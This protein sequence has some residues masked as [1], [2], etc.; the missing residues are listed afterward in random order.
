[1]DCICVMT[2][3][4]VVSFFFASSIW[5]FYNGLKLF[6]RSVQGDLNEVISLKCLN[7]ALSFLIVRPDLQSLNLPDCP[8]IMSSSERFILGLHI[9]GNSIFRPSS[10]GTQALGSLHVG[11]DVREYLQTGPFVWSF[12]KTYDNMP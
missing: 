6:I 8:T 9:V 11:P 12:P 7:I 1:M 10:V 3:W 2:S 5:P 4:I